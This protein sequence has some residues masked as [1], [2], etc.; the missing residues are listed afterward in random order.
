MKASKL[1]IAV[2]SLALLASCGSG[3]NSSAAASSSSAAEASSVAKGTMSFL[4]DGEYFIGIHSNVLD[5][6]DGRK[7]TI[8]INGTSVEG[9]RTAKLDG[10]FTLSSTGSFA[11]DL[12]V[13]IVTSESEGHMKANAYGPVKSEDA[14]N[15]FA[16][17]SSDKAPN[18]AFV[19]I[20]TVA[21]EWP[22]QGDDEM[23][24]EIRFA[25]GLIA[26]DSGDA[27]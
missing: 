17:H 10:Q 2:S 4:K 20:N 1:L 11:H 19:Y 8:S 24:E 16:L 27:E 7:P 26:N 21:N 22:S 9:T 3:T 18:K 12:Y 13:T 5:L 23:D 6:V 25:W 15:F 14:G